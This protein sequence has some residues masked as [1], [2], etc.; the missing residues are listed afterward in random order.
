MFIAQYSMFKSQWQGGCRCGETEILK[1]VMLVETKK[2][3]SRMNKEI[4][5][6]FLHVDF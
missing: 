6:S 1:V 4:N 3:F 5:M 2:T